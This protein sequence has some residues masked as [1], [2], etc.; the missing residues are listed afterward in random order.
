MH[1]FELASFD[2]N[3]DFT[4]DTPGFW[5]K[6]W[7]NN[8]GLGGSKSDPDSLSKTLQSYHKYLW[9]KQLPNGDYMNL[10]AGSGAYYL[11]W[12]N[13]R[14]G[15]DS[16]ITSFRYPR[17]RKLIAQVAELVPNYRVF[18]EDF[19]R[20]TYTIGGSII[21]P[22][23]I[24][25]INQTRGCHPLIKD[26]WDLSLECIRRYYQGENSPLRETLDEDKRFFDLFVDFKGFVDYFYLQDCVTPDYKAVYFWLGNGDFNANP[27]PQTVEEYLEWINKETEFV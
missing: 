12:D 24:G 3:F 20:K 11:T 4:T 16:I 10:E 8:H 14:F 21:F 9:S 27:L 13:F 7:S 25:G 15:S 22:K 17:N 23:R 1:K 18:L 26:R 6:F 2:V 5:E 19:L